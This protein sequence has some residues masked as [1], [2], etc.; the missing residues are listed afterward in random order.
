M[1]KDLRN[2]ERI[3][4]LEKNNIV[5]QEILPLRVDAST[6]KYFRI[7]LK[8]GKTLVL[9]D[10]ELKRNRLPEFT[11]LSVFLINHGLHVPEVFIKD[12]EHG[13]LLIEDLGDDTFTHLLQKG[14]DE[15][16][17]YQLGTD[18]LIKIA[19]INERPKCC[20]DLTKERIVNDICFFADWY[21]PMSKGSQLTEDERQE[22]IDLITPLADLA[23]KV[24]NKMVLW[25]Y[26]VDNIMLTE[27][28]EEC[29]VID[30]QDAMWGPLTYDIMSLLEDARRDVRAD[31]QEKMKQVFFDSLTNI[32]KEDFDDSYAFFSMFR[33][34]RVLGR[35][36]ILG[37]VNGKPQYLTFVPHLWQMLEKT[38]QYPKFEKIKAWVDKVLPPQKRIIPQRKP[39]TEA[40]ILAAGRGVRMRELTNNKPKPLIEVGSKA[41]I[42]YNFDRVKNAGI[43]DVVVN[44]CYQGEMLKEHI[45]SHH[46]DFLITYSVETEALETGGGIKNALKY[47]KNDAF[48]VCNSDVFFEEE[49]I[50]PAMWRMM[51]AWDEN[52]YDIL[53]LLQDIN[54]IC[55]DKGN[56]DYRIINGKLKRNTHKDE[57]YPYMF[58]GIYIIKKSVFKNIE[59]IKFSSVKLFDKAQ[60]NGRL[61]YV[62]NTS[63]FYHVGTP[64]ALKMAEEKLKS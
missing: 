26:H 60:E 63:T 27:C 30:F 53:L 13:F 59:D 19:H 17:L 46:P 56:G 14:V 48:F 7:V 25:D 29:A 44:L 64:E 24:P 32:K 39:V 8:N 54:N 58:A 57:G 40:M 41:L 37:Y 50:K 16:F 42:D 11:E 62:V 23:F 4:F 20:K 34:M 10:D 55:G 36:T 5:Y 28:K 6:R 38:L 1:P 49:T 45:S 3:T 9:M 12:F 52:K 22:F 18:A 47:F 51:D 43:K 33:H 31:I 2:I 61:G 35:F 21:I 15:A